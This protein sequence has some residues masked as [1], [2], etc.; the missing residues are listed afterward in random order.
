VGTESYVTK[1]RLQELW[2]SLSN[3]AH[4]AHKEAGE[5]DVFD[6]DFA[7]RA[8][9]EQAGNVGIDAD[10]LTEWVGQEYVPWAMSIM[11]MFRLETLIG[12]TAAMMFE[13]GW[14]MRMNY[15]IEKGING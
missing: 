10:I 7:V 13:M 4:D 8:T 5:P 15:E 12:G 1:E 9:S 14:T 2:E 11:G 3:I 6:S